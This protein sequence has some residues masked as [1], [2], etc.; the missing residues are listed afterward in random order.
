MEATAAL[1]RAQNPRSEKNQHLELPYERESE[2]QPV[3]DLLL[4]NKKTEEVALYR[5]IH[6]CGLAEANEAVKQLKADSGYWNLV[7]QGRRTTRVD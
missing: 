5:Q 3:L 6:A 1:F 2:D 4:N 7:K